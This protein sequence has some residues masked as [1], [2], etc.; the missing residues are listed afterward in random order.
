VRKEASKKVMVGVPMIEVAE[1]VEKLILSKGAKP[2][3][4]CNISINEEAA[5]AT[6]SPEDQRRFGKDMV[7]LDIGIHLDGYIAD[8]AITI[9]LSG[10]ESLVKASEEALSSALG[11]IRAGRRTGEIGKVIEERISSFGY[12]PVVNLTGHG[13]Q[14]YNQ[15]A[16][17]M[18]PNKKLAGGAILKEGDVIAIEPFATSGRGRVSEYGTPEIYRVVS[19]K[20]VRLPLARRL[21]GEVEKYR[22]LPFARRWLSS[23]MELPL[24]QL[25]SSGILHGYP[26]L[27]E[28]KGALISQAEHTVIV[29]KDGCEVIT[30]KD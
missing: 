10:N 19:R 14:R 20:P 21:L 24:K 7:K 16:P 23:N 13:L 30:E 2:A 3:F 22:G 6:P 12:R 26:V 28:R 25:C 15:H 27:R 11:I 9:D 8:T 18:I 4:P 29:E 17:P 5:H 1:F